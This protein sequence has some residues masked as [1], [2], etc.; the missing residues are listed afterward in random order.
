MIEEGASLLDVGGE[1]TRP[2]AREIPADE[3]IR[4]VVPV[5][6]ALSR[7]FDVPLSVD[8]RK[9]PV[10]RAALEAGASIV[11]DVSGLA[12][13]PA[14]G[15]VAAGAGA[16]M[17]LMHMRG[18]PADMTRRAVY[19]DVVGEVRR[20]L[21]AALDRAFEAGLPREALVADPGIGF[22]KTAAQSLILLREVG[23]LLDLGVPLLVGPSRKSFLGE[24]LGV[25]APER[26]VGTAVACA[27]A[28]LGGASLFRVH[29]VRPTVHALAVVEA[30]GEGGPG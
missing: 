18:T 17:V 16:G 24:I 11:N 9:A 28:R 20:E 10:A 2:G 26:D 7:R 6:E 3:E 8:T 15:R 1:S 21:A 13:D 23:R 14:L 29:D 4:R 22:A 12:F 27:V 30:L 19:G 25:P 5:L